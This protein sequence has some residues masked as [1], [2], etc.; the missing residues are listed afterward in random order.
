[1]TYTTPYIFLESKAK[2]DS[3]DLNMPAAQHQARPPEDYIPTVPYQQLL[4]ITKSKTCSITAVYFNAFKL[5]DQANLYGTP[6][7]CD[8][9]ITLL[10]SIK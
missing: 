10:S 4:L 2:S 8:N 1:M 3:L 6:N 9:M 7:I 5:N